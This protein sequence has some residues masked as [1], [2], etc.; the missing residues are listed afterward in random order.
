MVFAGGACLYAGGGEQL[1]FG[2]TWLYAGRAWL[3]GG[4]AR[5]YASILVATWFSQRQHTNIIICADISETNTDWLLRNM[6][7][8]FILFSSGVNLINLVFSDNMKSLRFTHLHNIMKHVN[9]R[10]CW[11]WKNKKKYDETWP[12]LYTVKY[13]VYF[14]SNL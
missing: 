10:N 3:F 12:V 14:L 5:F 1:Y 13:T 8:F 11:T 4:G 7:W 2:G 9:M 6:Y